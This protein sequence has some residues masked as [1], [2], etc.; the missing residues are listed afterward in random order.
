M[1]FHIY[2]YYIFVLVVLA[3]CNDKKDSSDYHLPDWNGRKIV[4]TRTDSLTITKTYLPVYAQ[5]YSVSETHLTDL[6]A[7]ISIRNTD[8]QDSIYLNKIEYY[9]TD[10]K[11]IRKY[12]DAPVFVKPVETI[13]IVIKSSDND[14]GTGA[15]F[16][17]EWMAKNCT[18]NPIFEAVMISTSGQQGIS[19]TSRGV[20]LKKTN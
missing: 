13:E 9:N 16:I 15:N 2:L 7:T 5:I 12:I 1:K 17:F 10:G 4:A 3:S 14:G 6:V 20:D 8:T 18:T 11:L 19:F